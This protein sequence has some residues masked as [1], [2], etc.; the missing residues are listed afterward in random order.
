M[1]SVLGLASV[2]QQPGGSTATHLPAAVQRGC[3][4]RSSPQMLFRIC[5]LWRHQPD[6][7]MCTFAGSSCSLDKGSEKP[8][9]WVWSLGSFVPLHTL[10]AFIRPEG[11]GVCGSELLI[12]GCLIRKMTLD[13]EGTIFT[14]VF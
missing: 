1:H 14:F 3:G 9:R 12:Q 7:F 11:N 10:C 5:N 4:I 6:L 13:L 2:V 8:S